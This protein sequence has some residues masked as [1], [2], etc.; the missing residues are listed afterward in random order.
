M[1]YRKRLHLINDVCRFGLL[2][3]QK[4]FSCRNIKEKR[5]DLDRRAGRNPTIRNRLD[6]PTG[7]FYFRARFTLS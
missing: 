7:N 1:R 2:A 3:T 5:T 6:L 4:F